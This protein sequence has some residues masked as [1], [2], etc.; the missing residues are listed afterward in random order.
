MEIQKILYREIGVG[1]LSW[2]TVPSALAIFSACKGDIQKALLITANMG[3]DT[4][5]LGSLAGGLCGAKNGLGSVP[6]RWIRFVTKLEPQIPT[7][8]IQKIAEGLT[9]LRAKLISEK[10]PVY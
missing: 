9:N 7:G 2:E 10:N 4:D 5:T 3:G 6:K 8:N 1:P